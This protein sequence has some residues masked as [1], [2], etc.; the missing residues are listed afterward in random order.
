MCLTIHLFASSRL[1]NELG[2]P[3]KVA[4]L[5]GRKIRQ[6]QRYD[7]SK[8][9]TVVSYE[10][11][12]AIGRLD[13]INIEERNNFQSGRK[14]VAILSE[15]ASTGI[16]LQA[17]KRVENQRRRVHITLGESVCLW[18]SRIFCPICLMLPA[19]QSF[20]TSHHPRASLEC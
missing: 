8:D 13:Q 2:G 12:K 16:S 19:D 20:L 5:T 4:E 1:V 7:E 11:R 14:V 17:D 18:A 6:I 10:R 9:R 15:A 3:D